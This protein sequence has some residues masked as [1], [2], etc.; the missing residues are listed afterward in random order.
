MGRAEGSLAFAI[1]AAIVFQVFVTVGLHFWG[2]YVARRQGGRW[3]RRA[4]WM[5]IGAF[6][7][8]IIGVSLTAYWLVHSFRAVATVDPSMKATLLARGISNAMNCTAL[9]AFPSWALFLASVVVFTV[10]SLMRP[11]QSL[12][13]P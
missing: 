13:A 12:G 10:G 11:R 7:L 2:R 3:W 1:G 9:F 5:P 4:A 8:S 6:V